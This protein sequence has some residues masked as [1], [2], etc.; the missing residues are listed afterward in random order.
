ML[1]KIP[2]SL[3]I[4]T[5]LM[6]LPFI[7]R[8]VSTIQ[9]PL[10]FESPPI[11]IQFVD[12]MSGAPIQDGIIHIRWLTSPIHLGVILAFGGSNSDLKKE[13]VLMTGPDGVVVIPAQKFKTP[14]SYMNRVLLDFYHPLYGAYGRPIYSHSLETYRKS[15]ENWKDANYGGYQAFRNGKK[16][17][18]EITPLRKY[19]GKGFCDVLI[20][21]NG[22]VKEECNND[23]KEFKRSLK[24]ASQYFELLNRHFNEKASPITEIYRNRYIAYVESLYF[25][26]IN[27]PAWDYRFS[28]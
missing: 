26:S 10:S 16:S 14:F 28:E 4:L 1:K 6:L 25:K 11:E 27:K 22:S 24:D 15:A 20:R 17:V 21:P 8:G 12:E 5:V 7:H 13:L 3:K 18:F 2:K 19:V 9:Y 23:G